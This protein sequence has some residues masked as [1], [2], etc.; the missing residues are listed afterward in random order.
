MKLISYNIHNF[1]DTTVKK[2]ADALSSLKADV[3]CLNEANRF[4]TEQL[5]SELKMHFEFIPAGGKNFGNAILSN[6]KIIFHKNI[7]L[8]Y[9][10]TFTYAKIENIPFYVCLTHLD[11]IN[12]KE[13]LRQVDILINFLQ[14]EKIFN[15]PHVIMGDF[16]TYRRSDY[17]EQEWKNIEDERKANSWTMPCEGVV[18]VMDKH[19]LDC[20]DGKFTAHVKDPKYRIDYFWTRNLT[21]SKT[22]TLNIEL[23]DHYPIL[24]EI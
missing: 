21:I 17:T 5:A 22:K 7:Q 14:A 11:H 23:S 15:E 19:Y 10:R 12:E 9:C 2:L 16:N 18:H 3:I 6:T 24:L 1:A 4:K 20:S 13:R 8:S